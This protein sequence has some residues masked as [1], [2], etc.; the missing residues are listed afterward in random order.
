MFVVK[1]GGRL[2][3]VKTDSFADIDISSYAASAGGEIT[4]GLRKPEDNVVVDYVP[5]ADSR[6]KINGV[7]KS[8][9][10]VPND[11]KLKA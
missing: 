10:F 7:V 5:A 2:L 11:F 6:A 9:E 3:N 4:C 8:I 1:V